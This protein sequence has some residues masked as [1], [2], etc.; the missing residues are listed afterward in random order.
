MSSR[1]MRVLG[2]AALGVLLAV[3]AAD[4]QE[5]KKVT[6]VMDW[7]AKEPQHMAYWLAKERGWYKDAGLDVKIESGRGSFQVVQ[8]L[9]AGQADFG[10]VAAT[11]LTQAVAKQ[12]VPLKMVAVFAQRDV[13]SIAV[14]ESKGIKSLKDLEGRT[15]GVVPGTLQDTILP[16][17]GEAA[18]FDASKIKKVHTEFRLVYTQWLAGQFDVLGNYSIGTAILYGAITAKGEKVRNFVLSDHLPFIGHGIVVSDKKIAE[19]PKTVRAFVDATRKAWAYMIEKPTEAVTEATAIIRKNIDE[20]PPAT[21]MITNA[22][23]IVPAFMQVPDTKGKPLGWSNP[24]RWQ[25][26]ID[27]LAKYDQFPAK[28][29]TADLMTDQFVK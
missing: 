2:G 18:G 1:T 24:A 20:P 23:Q 4:A 11:T 16:A 22:L 17:W 13:L 21:D 27:V 12:K 10:N 28:P 25:Q 6:V 19:D 14:F 8:L 26:M 5:L 9:V 29:A 3:G 15:L 7:I